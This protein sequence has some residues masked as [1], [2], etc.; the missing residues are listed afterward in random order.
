MEAFYLKV[1]LFRSYDRVP[2][3][4]LARNCQLPIVVELMDYTIQEGSTA[5]AFSTGSNN[6]KIYTQSC[7]VE[8][9]RVTFT[10][11][12]GFFV[13]GRNSLQYLINDGVIPLAIDV[14]CEMSLP[15]GG[16]A[17]TPEEVLPYIT[18]AEIAANAAGGDAE[19]AELYADKAAASLETVLEKEASAKNAAD[20]AA[21]SLVGANAAKDGAEQYAAKA[22]DFA[23]TAAG[24]AGAATVSIGWDADG[25]FSIFEQEE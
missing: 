2:P 3:I 1:Y 18:R 22:K 10:P 13:P 14:Y 12:I 9:N 5:S 16:E 11:Q 15:D 8:G 7:T 21:Q 25:Y 17:V 23:N 19:K 6:G 20:E 4:K 24:Y